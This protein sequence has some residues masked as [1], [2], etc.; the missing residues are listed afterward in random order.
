MFWIPIKRKQSCAFHYLT[1]VS[2]VGC[3]TCRPA[4]PPLMDTGGRI[5]SGG[6]EALQLMIK[7]DL[8][9]PSHL[10]PANKSSHEN[11]FAT[12]TLKIKRLHILTRLSCA[13]FKTV[14][15]SCLCTMQ[16]TRLEGGRLTNTP[17]ILSLF[18][19]NVLFLYNC[20]LSRKGTH[21]YP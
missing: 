13:A 4:S 3:L 1:Y 16:E 2:A 19:L 9:P 17:A 18:G 8:S 15:L 14:P 11:V 12:P 6:K 10:T 7:G 5:I 21:L 20:F